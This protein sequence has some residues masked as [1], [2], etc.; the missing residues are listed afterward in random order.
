MI[1]L[2]EYERVRIRPDKRPVM[3]QRWENLLFLHFAIA[4]EKLRPLVP[5]QLDL[6]LWN[7]LAW[8][9]LVPFQMRGVRYAG[10]PALPYIGAF[11]ETNVRT[12]V[13]RGGKRPGVWFFSLEAARLIA[14]QVARVTFGL[15][16]HHALMSA[17]RSGDHVFYRSRRT[18]SRA[19][20]EVEAVVGAARE[21]A[22]PGSFEF[23][24]VER[25]LLY[26]LHRR[27]LME[28][29][30]HHE[31]YPLQEARL[32]KVNE[33][34]TAASRIE[35]APYSHILFSPGVEVDVFGLEQVR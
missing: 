17:R 8:I 18:T 2:E 21:A 26:S 19:G 9:G 25:Y 29:Q 28:G 20:S 1:E 30:V 4:P 31:P 27:R 10:T 22:E 6:D 15:P 16:Y 11:A 32:I 34:L 14:T 33:S 35:A 5:P 13:H 7:G 12:Y 24:L 23:F 3:H